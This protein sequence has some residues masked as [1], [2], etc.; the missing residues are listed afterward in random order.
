METKRTLNNLVLIKL[1]PENTS[2]KLKNGMDLY[3]DTSYDTEKHS[4]VTGEVW[5]LPS[6]L[7]YFGEGNRGMPWLTPMEIRMGDKAIIYYLAVINALKK[8]NKKFIIEGKDRYIFVPYS[9]VYAVIRGENIIPLNGYCL[10]EAIEDP[11][12]T[13]DKESFKKIGM[14]LIVG[15]RRSNSHVTYGR[16]KYVGTPNREYVDEDYTDE[17]CDVRVGDVVVIR[18]TN[19]IPLQY[20]LHAKIDG[21]AKYL[22]VQRRNLLAKI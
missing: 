13:S 7:S 1:D 15:A 10:I 8:E 19:D 3:I 21:G 22:R 2:V 14:E 18:K 11:S 16:V 5:G 4:T 20:S 6:H 12:I 17:G 9:S